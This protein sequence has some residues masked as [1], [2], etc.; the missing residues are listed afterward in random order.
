MLK[1]QDIAFGMFQFVFILLGALFAVL[2]GGMVWYEIIKKPSKTTLFVSYISICGTLGG[3]WNSS[4]QTDTSLIFVIEL[5]TV[6]LILTY[7]KPSPEVVPK[8]ASQ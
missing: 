8:E 5:L 3:L 2:L 1:T 6:G 4:L 7:Y